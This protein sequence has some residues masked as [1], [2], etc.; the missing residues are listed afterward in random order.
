ML[1]RNLNYKEASL[2]PQYLSIPLNQ[3]YN[4]CFH[5]PAWQSGG[6]TVKESGGSRWAAQGAS[7]PPGHQAPVGAQQIKAEVLPQIA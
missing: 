2:N 6:G 7:A 1:K 4:Q 5:R 3:S